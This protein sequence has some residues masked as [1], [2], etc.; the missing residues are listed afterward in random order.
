MHS[1]PPSSS[2]CDSPAAEREHLLLE[3]IYQRD[4]ARA[5]LLAIQARRA[6]A[7]AV[8]PSQIE[9]AG[10]LA[11][12][13][14]EIARKNNRP[15]EADSS[16][17]ALAVLP[18]GRLASGGEDGEIKLWPEDGAGEPTVLDH[19]SSGWSPAV[20]PDGQLARGDVDG[21]IKVSPRNG[22]GEP[23]VLDH[24]SSVWSLA[25]LPDGRLAS[26]GEDGKIKLWPKD[27]AGEPTVLDHGSWISSLAVLPDGRLAR[28]DVDGKIKLWLIEDEKLIAALCLRAGR[29]LSK[30]EWLRYLG[31]DIPWQPSCRDRRSNWR[32]PVP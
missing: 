7:E 29:N 22:A 16:V 2:K 19:G 12:E 14:I 15:P 5:H 30:D 28:G 20:L 32:T 4:R 10:A 17:S 6:D 24:G 11:L 9:L 1:S 21:M 3:A 25:V 18:D 23:T 27:G 26:G 13:S 31:S 8:T